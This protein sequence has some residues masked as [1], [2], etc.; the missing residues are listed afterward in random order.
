MKSLIKLM[1]L[2]ALAL[3]WRAMAQQRYFAEKSVV[4]FFSDGVVE[5]ISATN[6]K[7]TSIFD[8]HDGEVAYLLSIKDFQFVNKLMQVHFNEKYMDTEKFP[9]SSFQGQI[10]GFSL[11]NPGKQEVKAKGKLTLQGVTREIDVPGTIEV[12][13]NRLALR[14]KFIIKLADYDIKI[15]QIVWQNIAQ[16]VEVTVDFLYRP[17]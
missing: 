12:V 17:L 5:D 3:P 15:P 14:S 7:V 16:Q 8:A 11:N 10:T 2:L 13:D 4:S 1:L 9:K 6:S